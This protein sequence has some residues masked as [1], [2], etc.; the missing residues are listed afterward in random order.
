MGRGRKKEGEE[1]EVKKGGKEKKGE[2][3][4]KNPPLYFPSSPF[5]LGRRRTKEGDG[6]KT[7][8]TLIL[9]L[10]RRGRRKKREEDRKE[11]EKEVKRE[12]GNRKERV[13]LLNFE[14]LNFDITWPVEIFNFLRGFTPLEIF[15]FFTG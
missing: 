7:S 11:K 1:K 8:P 5:P 13:F 15:D 12:G 10:Q 2:R 3:K 6:D 14:H 9:P 4:R